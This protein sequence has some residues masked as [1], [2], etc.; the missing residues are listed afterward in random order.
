[1]IAVHNKR[2]FFYTILNNI[3]IQLI[4]YWHFPG[5]YKNFTIHNYSIK[6]CADYKEGEMTLTLSFKIHSVFG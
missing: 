1:M 3:E 2:Q 5:V 6:M 4:K